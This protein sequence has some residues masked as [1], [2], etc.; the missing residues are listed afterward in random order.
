MT[1]G[2]GGERYE[3]LNLTPPAEGFELY[4]L[5][6]ISES[7]ARLFNLSPTPLGGN[8]SAVRQ[9]YKL[10]RGKHTSTRGDVYRLEMR[11]C[12]TSANTRE[13]TSTD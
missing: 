3:S 8:V 12:L 11:F 10:N 9:Q 7:T 2:P 1:E 5:P 6:S 4:V 13:R